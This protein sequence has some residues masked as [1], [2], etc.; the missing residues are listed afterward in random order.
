MCI[1]DSV[2]S[3]WLELAGYQRDE[4]TKTV[5]NK[6]NDRPFNAADAEHFLCKGWADAKLT[7]GHYR[8]A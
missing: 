1:R 8:N 5:R 2:N 7:Q 6:M 4:E 3:E